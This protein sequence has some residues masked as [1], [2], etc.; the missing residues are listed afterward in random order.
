MMPPHGS[1]AKPAEFDH[2][3]SDLLTGVRQLILAGKRSGEGYFSPDGRWMVFQAE[4]E[5]GNPFYQIY[6]LDRQT[7]DVRRVSPG[8][9]KT[10]CAWIHPSGER[11]LFAST[12]AD[13]QTM[14]KMRAENEFR[15]SGQERRQGA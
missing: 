1:N 14:A 9:G 5:P 7:G 6:L 13:P 2:Q 15:A 4:R 12:H 11:V 8:Y 10:T 3:E